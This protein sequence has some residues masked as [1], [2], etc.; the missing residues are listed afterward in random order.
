MSKLISYKTLH[1]SDYHNLI[2]IRILEN[3]HQQDIK[4]QNK[5]DNI[6]K[7]IIINDLLN[8]IYD[9][10]KIDEYYFTTE[11]DSFYTNYNVKLYK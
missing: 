1:I 11:S 9:Y 2:G 8:I 6:L 5:I 10:S 7:D 4:I 3:V